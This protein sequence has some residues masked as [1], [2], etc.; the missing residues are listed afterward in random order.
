MNP[1]QYI[2]PEDVNLG[3]AQKVRARRLYLGWKQQTL[4]E[5]SGVSLPSLRRFEN[6]GLIS[7]SSLLNL[8]M[9]LDCLGDFSQVFDVPVATSIADLEQ[10]GK[11]PQRGR[12]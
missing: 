8:A 10:K 5:R 1:Y 9:A 3:L 7:L 4:A 12:L 2:T 6:K 11:K